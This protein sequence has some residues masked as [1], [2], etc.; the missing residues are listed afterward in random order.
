MTAKQTF[1]DLRSSKAEVLFPLPF[2]DLLVN[3]PAK[4]SS[5]ID[6]ENYQNSEKKK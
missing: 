5:S 6:V 3:E 1:I 4:P 2:D